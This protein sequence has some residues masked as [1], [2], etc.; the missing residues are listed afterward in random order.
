MPERQPRKTIRAARRSFSLAGIPA[1]TST[2]DVANQ[3]ASAPANF[4][5]S[6][7]SLLTSFLRTFSPQFVG[8]GS[9]VMVYEPRPA[10]PKHVLCSMPCWGKEAHKMKCRSVPSHVRNFELRSIA[11]INSANDKA[12]VDYGNFVDHRRLRDRVLHFLPSSCQRMVIP[13]ENLNLFFWI[14]PGPNQRVI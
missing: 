3:A 6:K 1:Q 2:P 5:L 14:F 9:D 10:W 12:P 8:S 7:L 4:L 13:N 11:L